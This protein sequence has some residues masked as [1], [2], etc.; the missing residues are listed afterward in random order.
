MHRKKFRQK[1]NN[2]I[3]EGDKICREVIQ[4]SQIEIEAILALPYWLETNE[5][6]LRVYKEKLISVK[7]TELKKI[8]ALTTANQVV[9]IAKQLSWSDRHLNAPAD[10]SL[11]LDGLQDPGN[12]GTVLR[13]ADWFGVSAVYCAP[14]TVDLYNAKVL[15][16]SMGA[17][18]RI[19]VFYEE[20]SLL[21]ERLP[22]V[23]TYG[24]V[25]G[26]K[27]LF[28]CK[29]DPQGMI[30]IGNEGKGVRT[31]VLAQLD[32]QLAIPAHPNSG[33]ESLNAAM[34]A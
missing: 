18:L 11:Y 1:Y 15:Q 29:L 9:I 20:F 30:V 19:P 26:G 24:M 6:A 5:R 27:N 31:E 17:F 28:E 33:A 16:A 3:V 10:L 25:L 23:S 8:S 2:F 14:D 32:Q 22:H 12:L 4:S 21:K 13:M 7:P 34:A